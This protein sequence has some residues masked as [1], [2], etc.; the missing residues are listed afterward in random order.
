MTSAIASSSRA[1][2]LRACSNCAFH[3]SATNATAAEQIT[4]ISVIWETREMAS[5]Q[6]EAEE[7]QR[8]EHE[9]QRASSRW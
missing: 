4:A 6:G 8:R 9:G 1:V 3:S 2:L 5:S 7:E